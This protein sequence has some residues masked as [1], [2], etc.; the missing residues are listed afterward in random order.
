MKI[1]DTSQAV[2]IGPT[3]P[4]RS[5]TVGAEPTADKVSADQGQQFAQTVA[6][7]QQTQISSRTARL[8]QLTEAV[9]NGTYKPDAGRIAENILDDAEIDA[10]MQ[11]MLQR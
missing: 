6:V 5:A 10:R 2:P 11:A 3:A 9:R 7:A 8:Q 4:V 1:S